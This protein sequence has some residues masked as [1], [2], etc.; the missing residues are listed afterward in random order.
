MRGA[1]KF[2]KDGLSAGLR[3]TEGGGKKIPAEVLSSRQSQIPEHMQASIMLPTA[4][5]TL[6]VAQML[7]II[8]A[9][10]IAEGFYEL[11]V[12]QASRGSMQTWRCVG[13]GR[14]RW[15]VEHPRRYHRA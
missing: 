10:L 3:F 12:G 11:H 7:A 13:L 9:P 6:L 1:G 5:F 14:F 4:N 8:L 15:G 2:S